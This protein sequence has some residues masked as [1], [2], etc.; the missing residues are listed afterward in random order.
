MIAETRVIT[1]RMNDTDSHTLEGARAAGGYDAA[2]KAFAMEPEAVTALVKESGLRGRGGAG[3]PCGLK[4]S[5]LRKERDVTYLCVNADESEP[6]TFKDR[7]I[8][9]R[10]P[11]LLIEGILIACRAIRCAHAYLYIRGEFDLP[12]RRIR[13]AAAEAYRAGLLG[14]DAAGSGHPID[15]TI[16]RGAGA[17][18]CGEETGLLNSLEGRKGQPRIKPPF[19][20]DAGLFGKPTV[21]NNVETLANLPFILTSGAEAY[22]AH[23]TE[24]SPGTRLFGVSGHVERPGLFEL[25]MGVPMRALIEDLCGGVRGGKRLKAVIPGGS[26]TPVLTAE[27]AMAVTLDFESVQEAGS[28]LGSAGVIVMDET[29]D[30]VKALDVLIRFYAHESCGQCTPCRE[31]VIWIARTLHKIAEGRGGRADLEKLEDLAH[32][33][34]GN[35]ICVFSDAAAMPVLSFLSKFRGE[36][37]A[38]V[39]GAGREGA[40]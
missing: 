20:T 23:G 13:D 38:R 17:Y 4:W 9:E 24:K 6:G 1:A 26:S 27:E 2:R 30:M 29:T 10:D 40:A 19:P 21:I 8:L 18:I 25:A 31:G 39:S 12:Y 28:M 35:T 16:H 33:I 5:F 22:R 3:F 14:P 37:E 34:T 32:G 36:F 11:H 7:L 15:L